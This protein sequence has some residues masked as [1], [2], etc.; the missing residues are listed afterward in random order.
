MAVG[1]AKF[2]HDPPRNPITRLV[3][4][5]LRKKTLACLER[6]QAAD[7]S[8]LASP[9][10]TAF[11]VMNLASMGCQEHPIVERGIEFLL[12]S[13]R[14]DASWSVATNLA[15]TNTALAI[16]SLAADHSATSASQLERSPRRRCDAVSLGRKRRP[17][18]DT[19]HD[20]PPAHVAADADH[21]APQGA[22]CRR[23]QAT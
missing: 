14:A 17:H 23:R 9:L 8:F 7:D 3:R 15:T 5:S 13:V 12:S 18:N 16:D 1:L 19:I 22:A 11:V 20:H 21:S 4:G 6:L 2:H 10:V